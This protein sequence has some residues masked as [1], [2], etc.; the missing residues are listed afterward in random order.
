MCIVYNFKEM[1]AERPKT[2][3]LYNY[4]R[5]MDFRRQRRFIYIIQEFK[6]QI[7]TC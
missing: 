6:V 3:I 4:H 2:D 5:E 7:G 1:A